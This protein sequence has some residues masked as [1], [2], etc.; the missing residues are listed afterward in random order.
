MQLES[1]F[2]RKPSCVPAL[3]SRKQGNLLCIGSFEYI[4][5]KLAIPTNV[6]FVPFNWVSQHF[7]RKCVL[8]L[9]LHTIQRRYISEASNIT[10]WHEKETKYIFTQT[11]YLNLINSLT[12]MSDLQRSHIFL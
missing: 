2:A 9:F 11:P 3:T 6:P 5:L 10:S 7:N 8:E 1:N 12:E 4:E